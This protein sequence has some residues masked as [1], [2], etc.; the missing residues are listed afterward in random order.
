M[1]ISSVLINVWETRRG[2]TYWKIQ[3]HMQHWAQGTRNYRLILIRA[4]GTYNKNYNTD[5]I[6]DTLEA[7]FILLDDNN[8]CVANLVVF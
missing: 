3:R 1:N 4:K 2:N 7:L 6:E 8:P 5:V